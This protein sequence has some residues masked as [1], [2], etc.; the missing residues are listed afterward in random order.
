[1]TL[2]SQPL[3]SPP[4]TPLLRL[5]SPIWRRGVRALALVP[6]GNPQRGHGDALVSS[7]AQPVGKAALM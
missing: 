4:E 3:D 1:Q 5:A 6:T 2:L 7:F